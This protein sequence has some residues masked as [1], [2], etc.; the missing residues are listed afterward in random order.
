MKR[1]CAQARGAFNDRLHKLS[2]NNNNNTTCT[3]YPDILSIYN[4][5]IL[6]EIIIALV[7]NMQFF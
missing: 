3:Q 1:F 4:N 7:D 5:G 6:S 2:L